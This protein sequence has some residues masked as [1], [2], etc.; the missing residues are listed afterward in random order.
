MAFYSKHAT[1]KKPVPDSRFIETDFV[2]FCCSYTFGI[3]FSNNLKT[4]SL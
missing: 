3:Q 1:Y 2:V 4:N